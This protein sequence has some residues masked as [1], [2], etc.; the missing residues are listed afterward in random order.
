M[1]E[2]SCYPSTCGVETGDKL[3]CEG[4]VAI[5]IFVRSET[6]ELIKRASGQLQ[7]SSYLSRALERRLSHQVMSSDLSRR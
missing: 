4:S 5:A 6:K 1:A 7:A 2:N 3:T